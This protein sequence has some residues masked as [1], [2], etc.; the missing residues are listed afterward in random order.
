MSSA[1]NSRKTRFP[2]RQITVIRGLPGSGKSTYARNM[3]PD[4][5]IVEGDQYYTWSDNVYRFGEGRF[6]SDDFVVNMVMYAAQFEAPHI[7]V[8]CTSPDLDTVGRIFG[9]AA[10]YHYK[11]VL[12]W[13]EY[14][15]AD[16]KTYCE[17]TRHHVPEDVIQSMQDKWVDATTAKKE[18]WPCASLVPD[19]VLM[20]RYAHGPDCR[21]PHYR[22][23]RKYPKWYMEKL[24][25]GD[26]V[27]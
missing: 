23:T 10:E 24:K 18:G 2:E 16:L 6:R 11:P 14:N 27:R 12:I 1:S 21:M 7:V 19:E 8:T 5:F 26:M 9:L 22:K 20:V 13:L 25:H 17:C 4:A 15:G 3:W